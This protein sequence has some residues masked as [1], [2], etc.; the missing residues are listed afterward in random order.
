MTQ[1]PDVLGA[2]AMTKT[3]LWC[4]IVTYLSTVLPLGD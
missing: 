4:V 2:E 3:R 1:K